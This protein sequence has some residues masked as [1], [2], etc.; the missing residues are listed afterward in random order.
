MFVKNTKHFWMF[1]K[2]V[3]REP[4]AL[5]NFTSFYQNCRTG[6]MYDWV[7]LLSMTYAWPRYAVCPRKVPSFC[8]RPNGLMAFLFVPVPELHLIEE[9]LRLRANSAM[10]SSRLFVPINVRSCG[11]L[12]VMRH[13][14]CRVICHA[15][16]VL[17]LVVSCD[18]CATSAIMSYRS[19]FNI[20]KMFPLL[21]VS[22]FSVGLWKKLIQSKRRL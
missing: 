10:F 11:V 13:V 17:V 15:E 4:N 19:N 16:C 3:N 14:M 12:F 9:T 8:N 6:D 21:P 18:M 22:S 2:N 7:Y 20:K 1:I 5:I